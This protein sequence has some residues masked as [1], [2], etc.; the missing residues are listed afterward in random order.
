MY[1]L[2][3]IRN[4]IARYLQN[5]GDGAKAEIA[6]ENILPMPEA[7]PPKRENPMREKATV[8]VVSKMFPHTPVSNIEKHLPFVLDGLERFGVLDREMVLMALATIRAETEGFVPISEYTSKY[9]TSPGSA[10]P[11]D[12]YDGR[13]DLGNTE[14]GDGAK[15]HGRGF[16]QLTGRHNYRLIGDFLGIDLEGFPQMANDA[17]VAADILAA[18]LFG[19][20]GAIR[21]AVRNGDLARARR[22]VNGGTHGLERF[23]DAFERGAE[24]LA[25]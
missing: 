25:A 13:A 19:K 8:G 24:A 20:A 15:Y 12:L 7:K 21:E 3:K 18:Y 6:P 11:Y 2:L 17:P 10:N 9:N 1:I 4:L 23:V 22:L 5:T 16:I 14:P